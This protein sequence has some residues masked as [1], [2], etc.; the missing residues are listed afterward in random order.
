M[1]CAL[2]GAAIIKHSSHTFREELTP[3]LLKLFPNISEEGILPKAFYES[4]ITLIPKLAKIP[5]P[6]ALP[7]KP[8][9][10]T[11]RRQRLG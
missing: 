8:M 4:T 3:I 6:L 2:Q 5:L 9:S 11:I 7:G 10:L 1:A